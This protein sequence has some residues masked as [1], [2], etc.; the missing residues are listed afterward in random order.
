MLW[1]P[2]KIVKLD[3]IVYESDI[4]SKKVILASE[5]FNILVAYGIGAVF[6]FS[7]LPGL[8]ASASNVI[9]DKKGFEILYDEWKN[10]K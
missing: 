3:Q 4:K 5:I 6:P 1:L 7:F 8:L 9:Q 2:I 10:S